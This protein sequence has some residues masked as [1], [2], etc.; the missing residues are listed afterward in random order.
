MMNLKALTAITCFVL[1][2]ASQALGQAKISGLPAGAVVVETRKLPALKHG[3]R[4]LALWMLNPKRNPNGYA[5]DEIYPCPD[6]SRGSY[7]SGPTRVSLLDRATKSIINT[8]KL[9]G[10][11]EDGGDNVELPYAIRRGYYYRVETLTRKGS[12]PSRQSCG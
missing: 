11:D 12:K 4:A 6:Q 9:A 7:Y 5:P 1:C 8:I 2:F 10:A 3:S